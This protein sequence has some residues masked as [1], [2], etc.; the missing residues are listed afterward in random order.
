[1]P[2]ARYTHLLFDFFGTLV[3]YSASRTEQGF[4]RSHGLLRQLG[5]DL[6][7]EEFL[8]A[9]SR[10]A[11]EFDRLSDQDDHEFSMND[12]GTAFL[13]RAL[14]RQP[15]PANVEAFTAQ[16]I[17]EWN[18][19]V[20]YPA[21]IAGLVDELAGTYRLAV[22]TN[23]H[24]PGL[25]CD[26]LRAMGVLSSFDAVVTSVEVGWRK[27]HPKIYSTAL[28]TLGIHASAATFVGDTYL[29]DYVGP[30]REGIRAFLIDPQCRAAVPDTRRLSSIF[31]LPVR[32]SVTADMEHTRRM[33]E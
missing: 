18:T 13:K 23:T 5:A 20:H 1:M 14:R 2:P 15:T 17:D 21:G 30:E 16:Y 26:H 29:P 3:E 10:V 12:V 4:G 28:D 25:V 22:V 27:P 33:P 8:S 7:Y 11:A 32:L 31:D 6:A 9:W 24:E 19:G